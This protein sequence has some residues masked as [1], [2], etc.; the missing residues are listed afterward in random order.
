MQLFPDP[1]PLKRGDKTSRCPKNS[2]FHAWA[3]DVFERE[4]F[5][6]WIE[7]E[8]PNQALEAV[9]SWLPAEWEGSIEVDSDKTNSTRKEPLLDFW[10]TPL[11]N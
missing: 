6:F 5:S 10:R 7:S 2:H 9:V 8:T 3:S 4:N 11:R 1:V